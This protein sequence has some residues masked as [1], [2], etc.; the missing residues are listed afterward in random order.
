MLPHDGFQY[1]KCVN[2]KMIT[3]S[4]FQ[5][6]QFPR[7]AFL[8]SKV[9][10][11]RSKQKSVKRM[12][13]AEEAE[14]KSFFKEIIYPTGSLILSFVYPSTEKCQLCAAEKCA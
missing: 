5:Q 3:L 14:E 13:C 12:N 6:I 4:L 2:K 8:C 7:V 11:S 9:I 1:V 10:Y